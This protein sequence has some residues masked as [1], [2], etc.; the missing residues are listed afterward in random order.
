MI[1]ALFAVE[2]FYFEVKR[3]AFAIIFCVLLFQSFLLGIS[4]LILSG[5]LGFTPSAAFQ[6][7]FA[8]LG[9]VA[10][11]SIGVTPVFAAV[12][13]IFWLLI[14]IGQRLFPMVSKYKIEELL[15]I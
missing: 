13:A 2:R 8:L 14:K 5:N 4:T 10:L 6:S 1:F 3:G 12:C 7:I 11:F 9:G 15:E